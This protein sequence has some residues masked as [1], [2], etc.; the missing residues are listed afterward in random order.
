M[1]KKP[2][3]AELALLSIAFIWGATFILVQTAIQSLP[4][5]S[6]LAIRFGLATILM[7]TL[8]AFRGKIGTLRQPRYLLAGS[9]LGAWLFLGY[10]LQTFSLLY[11]TSG[12]SGFLTGV[13]V[14][15]VPLFSFWILGTKPNRYAIIGVGFALCGLW[16]LAFADF[17]HLNIGDTLAFLCAIGFGLQIVYT[18]KYA[19]WADALPIATIQIGVVA[20][21]STCSSLIFESPVVDVSGTILFLPEVLIALIVTVLFATVLAYVGQAHFQRHTHP[22]R[23]ALIFAMEPVFA[24]W[25]DWMWLD[26]PM[27]LTTVIGCLCILSGMVLAETGNRPPSPKLIQKEGTTCVEK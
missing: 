1:T 21:F 19:Q 8:L 13:S 2:G 15:L 9:F 17:S 10:A 23:V 6:F 3:I 11:T 26:T 4:P 20:L 7:G 22:T 14:A 5:F 18:G 16:L 12:K 27:S 24:A 25:T